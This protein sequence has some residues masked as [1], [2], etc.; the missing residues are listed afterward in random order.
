MTVE[1]VG[2]TA[3]GIYFN[4][5]SDRPHDHWMTSDAPLAYVSR[6]PSGSNGGSSP[7]VIMIHGRGADEKDLL[8]ISKEL[9]DSVYVLSVRG[10]I[11]M[12]DGY[13]WYHMDVN[14][15]GLHSSQPESDSF[16]RSIVRLSK[17][18]AYA[19][20]KYD[21]DRSRIGLLGFSQGAT[22]AMA[23][24]AE[25]PE[26]VGWVVGLNGYLP[27]EYRNA[28]KLV[29]ARSVP[30]FL[31][32][33]RMDLVVPEERVERAR[34]RLGDVGIDVTYN[35]YNVGHGANEEAINDVASWIRNRL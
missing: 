34:D 10:P 29:D 21:L 24:A 6:A 31:A 2:W 23:T 7:A 13:A 9:P 8:P 27:N 5:A 11:E 30:M 4:R 32:A 3:A 33:G 14:Q 15:G 16:R 19:A 20:K 25:R 26:R 35:A 22:L 12:D 1:A 28:S 17:F 18:I